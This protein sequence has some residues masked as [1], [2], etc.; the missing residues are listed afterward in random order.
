[1][2]QDGRS[3]S[4]FNPQ[5][6]VQHDYFVGRKNI[7]DRIR[8][9]AEQA[10]QGKTT[11]L[12]LGGLK[13][14]GKT[15]L[16]MM[17]RLIF[18]REL[19]AFGFHLFMEGESGPRNALDF[20]VATVEKIINVKSSESRTRQVIHEIFDNL[21]LEAKIGGVSIQKKELSSKAPDDPSKFL[22]FARKIH[23]QL[24]KDRDT[25][26]CALIFDELD[27]LC[28]K[29]FFVDFLKGISDQAATDKDPSNLLIL[30]CGT[31]EKYYSMQQLEHRIG[32][33]IELIEVDNLKREDVDEFYTRS[34]G[35]LGKELTQKALD[36]LILFADG[37][38]QLMHLLGQETYF[39]CS[40][41]IQ[42]D[43]TE[44]HYG[45]RNA[46]ELRLK[47]I[48]TSERLN[49]LNNE[50]YTKIL[51]SLRELA[52]DQEFDEKDILD[53]IGHENA[54]HLNSFL[55]KLNTLGL[56]QH[57]ASNTR[58]KFTDRLVS[59]WFQSQ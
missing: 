29:R 23:D 36:E 4:P 32:Q 45:I 34:F 52:I 31:Q 10:F 37:K 26:G 8:R 51:Q 16:A 27:S 59:I 41:R 30:L 40:D 39:S 50:N 12:Y 53:R 44:V 33:I 24:H 17:S 56:A 47:L 49:I 15:S 18:E 22:S 2:S 58:W 7:L 28:S 43:I 5:G 20:A 38:P 35:Y 48:P 21:I 9:H 25:Q 57:D 1:M 11:I 46:S 6:P 14:I 13:G 42:V 3:F 54:E 19:D 55:S